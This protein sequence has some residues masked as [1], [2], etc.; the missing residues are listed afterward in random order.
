MKSTMKQYFSIIDRSWLWIIWGLTVMVLGIILFFMHMRF[1][2]QFTW[3][4]EMVVDT[5]A[6]SDSAAS[7]LENTLQSEWLTND[8]VTVWEKDG[9]PSILIQTRLESEWQIDSIT[10]TIQDTLVAQWVISWDQDILELSII[11]PSIGD[12][13][14]QSAQSALIWGIVAMAIYVLIAFAS[15]RR[16]VSPFMLGVITIVTMLFDVALPAGAYG[17]LMSMNPVVQIDT[18]FII[19]LLTV[20]WYSVND[21][22]IIFDRVRENI[23]EKREKYE[24][25]EISSKEIFETSIWQT[26]KRSIGT[27]LSTLVVVLAMYLFGTWVLK[28]FAFTLGIWVIAGTYSS[29]FLA[30]PMAYLAS[31]RKK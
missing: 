24:E 21:T 9:F 19:A 25:W 20:M 22:I 7:S 23:N 8:P 18:V 29:I 2:I 12:Y 5:V 31:L 16:L 15:M 14:K 13:I 1:S 27:S 17:I 3:G 4:V 30:A 26:M 11:W 6:I 28:T 10:S